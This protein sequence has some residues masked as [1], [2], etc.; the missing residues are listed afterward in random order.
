VMDLLEKHGDGSCK[1]CEYKLSYGSR[2]SKRV[3]GVT[4]CRACKAKRR[5][6]IEGLS[7]RVSTV[8]PTVI[9][10]AFISLWGDCGTL[11]SERRFK[12]RVSNYHH[13]S[14]SAIVHSIH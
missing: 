1:D 2:S 7:A 5:T 11:N 6:Y 12:C 13:G 14:S 9:S 8:F 10:A 3:G 4:V